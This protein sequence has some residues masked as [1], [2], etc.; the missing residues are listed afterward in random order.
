MYYFLKSLAYSLSLLS[1]RGVERF[2]YGLSVFCFDIIRIRRQVTVSNLQIA[3]KDSLS[4]K[5]IVK[6]GRRSFYHFTLTFLELFRSQKH[7]I[8]S[9]IEIKGGEHLEKALAKGQGV[10]SLCFHMGNWEAMCSK[11]SRTYVDSH[12]IVKKV[13]SDKVNRF[14]EELRTHNDFH[15]IR[16][17]KGRKGDALLQMRRILANKE[18]IGFAIDQARPGEPRLP[19]FGKPAKTNTSFA[20]IWFRHPAPI[21]P[22][23][24]RRVSAGKHILEFLPEFEMIDTGDKEADIIAN[25]IAFNKMVESVV[26][27]YPEQYF[28]M[29]NRWKL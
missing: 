28:W 6:L 16:R 21:I 27:Q 15:W 7:N 12:V 19:F 23:F 26:R 13:G 18:I 29:H 5:D 22:G 25:S 10:Y 9:D 14:V 3:F 11:M 24:I 20:A 1:Q 2:A 4:Q 8:S 17:R